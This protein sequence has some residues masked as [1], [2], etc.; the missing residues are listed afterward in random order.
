MPRGVSVLQYIRSSLKRGLAD[1]VLRRITHTVGVGA[2]G[3]EGERGALAAG[4][5]YFIP[6]QQNILAKARVSPHKRGGMRTHLQECS[7]ERAFRPR[8]VVSGRRNALT[9]IGT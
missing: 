4:F 9:R 5:Y 7:K 1:L 6:Q 2:A 8:T 3:G